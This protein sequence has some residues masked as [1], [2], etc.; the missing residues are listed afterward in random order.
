MINFLLHSVKKGPVAREFPSGSKTACI[1]EASAPSLIWDASG[2]TEERGGVFLGT[3][4]TI[5]PRTALC[6]IRDRIDSRLRGAEEWL[7]AVV[8]NLF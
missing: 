3:T 2:N 8:F 6:Y 4:P 7:R 1:S 5:L